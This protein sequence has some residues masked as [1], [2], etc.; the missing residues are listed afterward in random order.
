[1]CCCRYSFCC[2]KSHQ[3]F[4]CACSDPEIAF[5]NSFRGPLK[6]STNCRPFQLAIIVMLQHNLLTFP[7]SVLA[8]VGRLALSRPALQ[9]CGVSQSGVSS[10][11]RQGRVSHTF[12]S[13]DLLLFSRDFTYFHWNI[14]S[15]SPIRIFIFGR[16]NVPIL[17]TFLRFF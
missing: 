4:A 1:M 8:D 16:R 12:Y 9:V 7:R 5:A 17:K 11:S 15:S 10:L 13:R 14:P 3:L 6:K 2:L